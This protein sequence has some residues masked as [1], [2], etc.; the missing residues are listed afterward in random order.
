VALKFG[1][2]AQFVEDVVHVIG[3]FH[4]RKT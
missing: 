3:E 1:K 2:I 4:R